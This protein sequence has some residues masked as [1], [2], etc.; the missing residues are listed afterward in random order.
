MNDDV[1]TPFAV[2][3]AIQAG[4]DTGMTESEAR[5]EARGA[6]YDLLLPEANALF[7]RFANALIAGAGYNETQ[8]RNQTINLLLQ[9]AAGEACRVARKEG[10]EPDP[11]LWAAATRAA[12]KGA[13]RYT[14]NRTPEEAA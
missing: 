11:N 12:F 10:R 8:A 14:A 1:E 4:I 9:M 13:V 7:N 2:T 3:P 6:A 5:K